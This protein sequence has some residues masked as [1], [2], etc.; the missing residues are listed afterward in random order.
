MYGLLFQAGMYEHVNEVYKILIPI[1]ES[2]RDYKKLSAIHNKLYEAFN[3]ITRQASTSFVHNFPLM[4]LHIFNLFF[5]IYTP[6]TY[7]FAKIDHYLHL[8][9]PLFD[10]LI[11]TLNF[12]CM[13]VARVWFG[14]VKE[15][16]HLLIMADFINRR[17]SGCLGPTSGWASMDTSLETWMGTSLCTK[18]RP[19]P[20]FQRWPTGWR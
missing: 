9:C 18:S 4:T 6:G 11:T 16:I 5:K 14:Q 19:L 12:F 8:N 10:E 2:G 3:N 1:H 15:V 7:L 17:V 13:Y 20:S